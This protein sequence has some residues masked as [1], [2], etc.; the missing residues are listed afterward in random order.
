MSE[1]LCFRVNDATREV[2]DDLAYS[3]RKTVAEA[4]RDLIMEALKAR[5][6]EA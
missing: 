2:V 6:I 5:G 1:T 4:S 3:E